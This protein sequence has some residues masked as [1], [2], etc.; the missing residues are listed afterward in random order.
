MTPRTT[1][2][3]AKETVAAV[4]NKL[5]DT[6]A[7]LATQ[8]DALSGLFL[9]LKTTDEEQAKVVAVMKQEEES[10]STVIGGTQ[11]LVSNLA[12][13][14][15]SVDLIETQQEEDEKAKTLREDVKE[16]NNTLTVLEEQYTK[17]ENL[18]KAL[19]K[20]V[21]DDQQISGSRLLQERPPSRGRHLA[22]TTIQAADIHD[23]EVKLLNLGHSITDVKE[24]IEQ[25]DGEIDKLIL[26]VQDERKKA[27]AEKEATTQFAWYLV[28]TVAVLACCMLTVMAC[29]ARKLHQKMSRIQAEVSNQT[30]I[31][32]LE[33]LPSRQNVRQYAYF[34]SHKKN[35][36]Q[37]G[38]EPE[39]IAMG[40]HD[41]LKVQGYHGF[42]DID[43]LR[44]I[45][46]EALEEAVINSSSLIIFMH[47]ETCSSGWCVAEWQCAEA[48]G[49][50]CMVLADVTY[51]TV[52]QMKAQVTNAGCENLLAYPWIE[53]T[54]A[55]RNVAMDQLTAQLDEVLRGRR[56][57]AVRPA[58]NQS[59]AMPRQADGAGGQ[60]SSVVPSEPQGAHASYAWPTTPLWAAGWSLRDLAGASVPAQLV[61]GNRRIC[62]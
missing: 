48:N 38:N 39:A 41:K 28:A 24:V 1:T 16:L 51:A 18:I 10:F 55:K 47:D 4:L 33:I 53:Y 21:Q 17:I 36:T 44:D 61:I 34:L 31:L 29:I 20:T 50:S 19:N 23:L 56:R 60:L 46:K 35:H 8:A 2:A 42:F 9:D 25:L 43:N 12:A 37:F 27:P 7:T 30:E 22:T 13:K 5:S 54:E 49:I 26:E 59:N 15:S 11:V 32:R 3:I 40:I 52:N 57:P 6:L 62:V 45:S 58:N 14:I